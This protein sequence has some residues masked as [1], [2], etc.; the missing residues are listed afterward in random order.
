[1]GANLPLNA[2]TCTSFKPCENL[3]HEACSTF[4]LVGCLSIEHTYHSQ[5]TGQRLF[6]SFNAHQI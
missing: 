1:M 2:R 4:G 3:L 5:S 6:F